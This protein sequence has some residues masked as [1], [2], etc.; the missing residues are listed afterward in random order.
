MSDEN[1]MHIITNF[2]KLATTPARTSLLSI[3]EAGYRSIETSKVVRNGIVLDGDTLTVGNESYN[4]TEYQN[5]YVLGIGKCAH[6]SAVELEAVLGDRLTEGVVV[7]VSC[8]GDTL[9]KIRCL[10]G[11]HPFPS[12]ENVSHTRELLELAE[13]ATEHDLVIMIVSGGGSTL[14]CQPET[15]DHVDETKLVEY[16]FRAGATID[17]LNTIRRHL[18]KAR[19]GFVA[20]TA[21]PATL[22]ALIF[23]DVP[24]DDIR[25]ISSSPTVFDPTT[26]DDA[27]AVFDKYQAD[28]SGFSRE[29]FF[30]TPKDESIFKRVQN[31]LILKNTTALEAM[32]TKAE[33]LGYAAEIKETKLQGEARTVGEELINELRSA[34]KRTV[35]LYGGETTVTITGPGKGGRNQELS[36]AALPLIDEDEL[37]VSLASDGHDNTD[38]AGGIADKYTRGKAEDAKLKPEDFL[39]TND[40]FSFFKTLEQGIETGYT[41]ANVADLVIAIKHER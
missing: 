19:G 27:F 8:A 4:M 11:T 30:E 16:L 33:E 35:H 23:S 29:H 24:G 18:S 2:E 14:L 26:L 41:G 25:V 32:K 12:E 15:H 21:S 38:F 40:S 28:N 37:I 39:F 9:K 36:L 17:E 3:A 6:D 31:E 10:V 34:K 7:D 1:S 22:V 13:R 5:V 20:Q